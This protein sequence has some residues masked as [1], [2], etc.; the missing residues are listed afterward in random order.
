M[1]VFSKTKYMRH[2]PPL[3]RSSSLKPQQRDVA[4][5]GRSGADRGDLCRQSGLN[6]AYQ[7][8]WPAVAWRQAEQDVGRY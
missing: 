4:R 7:A 8:A 5:R 6:H 1:L 2:S 3:L